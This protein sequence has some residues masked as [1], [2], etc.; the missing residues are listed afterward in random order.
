M[1]KSASAGLA[2]L[3]V[4]ALLLASRALCIQRTLP[5]LRT[6]LAMGA[7]SAPL[8][9][10]SICSVHKLDRTEGLLAS[11]LVVTPLLT[12]W[13][14]SFP[15]ALAAGTGVGLMVGH[16]TPAPI[17]KGA[18]LIAG[19]A[20]FAF[21]F[22]LPGS[23]APFEVKAFGAVATLTYAGLGVWALRNR[24]SSHG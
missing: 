24:D 12:R 11:L 21:P 22:L 16:R 9:L 19:M 6:T 2:L 14:G 3:N 4:G 8:M 20:L 17:R 13:T 15:L 1:N 7:L 18:I 5:P 10:G 23:R